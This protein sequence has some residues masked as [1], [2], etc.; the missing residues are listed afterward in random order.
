MNGLQA[1]APVREP[2]TGLCHTLSA[3]L[4]PGDLEFATSGDLRSAVSARSG[5]LRRARREARA[6]RELA[7]RCWA[8]IYPSCTDLFNSAVYAA[9]DDSRARTGPA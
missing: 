4:G 5:D 3:R 7:V 2:P 1:V 8:W 9:D 6:E